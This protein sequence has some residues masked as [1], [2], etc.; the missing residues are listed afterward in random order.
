MDGCDR[1]DAKYPLWVKAE[2]YA[3]KAHDGQLMKLYSSN[4]I[5]SCISHALRV[6]RKV[7]EY[8]SN[9]EILAAATLYGVRMWTDASA[10]E[11]VMLFGTR[12]T[13]IAIEVAVLLFQRGNSLELCDSLLN[14]SEDALL[15]ILSDSFFH[16]RDIESTLLE[17]E[18]NRITGVNI[19]TKPTII[20]R[21]VSV[22]F[23]AILDLAE[24]SS[25]FTKNT[26]RLIEEVVKA[27][28]RLF[29]FA[30]DRFPM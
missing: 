18:L 3:T 21:D 4:R 19:E 24:K 20:S 30:M 29:T 22:K 17:E 23:R 16:I 7:S 5:V 28:N 14:I 10:I 9:D 26:V 27:I 2:S 15:L 11:M 1:I 12:T 13:T 8:T 6:S 25:K